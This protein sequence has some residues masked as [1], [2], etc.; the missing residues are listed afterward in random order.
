LVEQCWALVDLREETVRLPRNATTVWIRLAAGVLVACGVLF[1]PATDAAASHVSCGA[2]VTTNTT[3]DSDL[4]NCPGDGIVIGAPGITLDLDGHLIDGAG[5]G[6]GIDDEAGYDG[7]T[8]MNG[9]VQEFATGVHLVFADDSAFKLL[10]VAQSD[11][12]SLDRSDRNLISR[13]SVDGQI[14][15]FNDSDANVIE[16]NTAVQIAMIGG[17]PGGGDRNQIVRNSVLGA[18]FGIEA[19][20]GEDTSIERNFVLGGASGIIVSDGTLRSRVTLNSV[21][22]AGVGIAIGGALETVLVR[23]DASGNAGDG[24]NVGSA[25]FST[26]LDRNTAN[27]NGDDGI[28]VDQAVTALFGNTAND[29]ADFGI[30]SVFGVAD[31]GDNRASGNGNPAQC[32]NVAC[33]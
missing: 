2:V 11:A 29:N 23:N 30:E 16:R 31:G 17:D 7:I 14:G 8:V 10:T 24:I 21:S 27:R 19:T 33:R 3:L 9:R 4:V 5:S 22:G 28:D 13:N 6:D 15:I 26:T 18:L 12:F 20:N 1:A 25:S 32:L